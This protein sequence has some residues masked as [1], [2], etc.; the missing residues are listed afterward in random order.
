MAKY[1]GCPIPDTDGD[2]INDEQDKCPNEKGFARYQGCPI[3]DTDA[4]GV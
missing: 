3:P 4:D 1:G 2:G